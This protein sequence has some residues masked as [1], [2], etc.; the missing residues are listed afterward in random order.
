M[1][2]VRAEL[3]FAASQTLGFFIH[4]SPVSLSP[5][6]PSRLKESAQRYI[7]LLSWFFISV[8]LKKK[9]TAMNG[10]EHK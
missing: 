10:V 7:M 9:K 5:P 8:L 3:S 6:V 1:N 2:S 4:L